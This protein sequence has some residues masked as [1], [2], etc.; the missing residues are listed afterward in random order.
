MLCKHAFWAAVL[1]NDQLAHIHCDTPAGYPPKESVL[2]TTT[3]RATRSRL[4]KRSWSKSVSWVFLSDFLLR[5]TISLCF[6]SVLNF[7]TTTELMAE[8][9]SRC[10]SGAKSWTSP[11]APQGPRHRETDLFDPLS[12]AAEEAVPEGWRLHL[13]YDGRSMQ[14]DQGKL[15]FWFVCSHDC[16]KWKR[17]RMNGWMDKSV[18]TY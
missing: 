13:A 16:M 2:Q 18:L 11:R 14:K 3:S 4:R 15:T 1:T 9:I 12:D 17:A 6:W 5:T 8:L 10:P 7:W